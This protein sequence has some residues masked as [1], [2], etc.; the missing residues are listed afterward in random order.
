MN[1]GRGSLG[2]GL[3]EID[4]LNHFLNDKC[5]DAHPNAKAKQPE[6]NDQLLK[7]QWGFD[8][9]KQDAKVSNCIT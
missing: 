4:F 2:C 3:F 1:N 8:I 9:L 7:A 6:G 5:N